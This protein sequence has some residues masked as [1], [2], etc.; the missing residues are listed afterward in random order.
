[1]KVNF[2]NSLIRLLKRCKEMVLVQK[3]I[4]LGYAD[5]T[6]LKKLVIGMET[7]KLFKW[8][9]FDPNCIL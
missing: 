7:K 8:K 3:I 9:H 6:T 5:T 2:T 4:K 1:Q